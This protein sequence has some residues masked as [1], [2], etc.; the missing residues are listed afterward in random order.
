MMRTKRETATLG[1]RVLSFVMSLGILGYFWLP[2]VQIDG[3]RES[4]TGTQLMVLVGTPSL[5]YLWVASPISA[6]ALIGGPVV[7]LLFGLLVASRY[8][9]RRTAIFSTV[10]VLV[11]AVGL[12]Q[13]AKGL[14]LGGEPRYEAGLMLIIVMAGLLLVQQLLIKAATVLRTKGKFSALYRTLTVA[15]GSGQHLWRE[16]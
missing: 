9:Q 13:V 12:P 16:Q 2:W 14:L 8:A 10:V 3:M 7:I 11:V 15:T 4:S 1:V 6:G 5:D